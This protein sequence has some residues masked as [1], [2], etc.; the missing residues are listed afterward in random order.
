[1]DEL[2]EVLENM[3]SDDFIHGFLVFNPQ[4]GFVEEENMTDKDCQFRD[5]YTWLM[6]MALHYHDCL[7]EDT[8]KYLDFRMHCS[9]QMHLVAK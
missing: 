2:P 3:G 6:N 9:L 7:C 5:A 4:H 8:L 1:V